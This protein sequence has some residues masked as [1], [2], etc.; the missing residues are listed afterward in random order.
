MNND[1]PVG[2]PWK[3][4]LFPGRHHALTKYQ[5]EW[6]KSCRE[7]K[8]KDDEGNLIT[9]DD[10]T[11]WIFVI[12]SANHHTTR[13]NP[14]SVSRRIAQVELFG[15]AENLRALTLTLSDVSDNLR[16][17]EH[18]VA[19][20]H[21]ELGLTLSPMDTLVAVSTPIGQQYKA[22]GYSLGLIEKDSL[23]EVKTPWQLVE[24]VVYGEGKLFTTYAHEASQ[25]VWSRYNLSDQVKQVFLD[26]VVSNED[27]AL[28]DTR[29][30]SSYAQAFE[31]SAMRKW[32]QISDWVIPGRIVDIGS[33]TGQLL[34][35]AG[36]D[37]RLSQSDLIGIEPDR[38]LHAQSVHR[39]EQGDFDNVN[40][41]FYRKNILNGDVFQPSSVDTTITA[42]LTHEIYSY[43]DGDNDL[44]KIVEIISKQTRQNGVW[45]NLDVCGPSNGDEIIRLRLK[46]DD[47][48]DLD[49]VDDIKSLSNAE[50]YQ[51]LFEASTWARFK[52]FNND[53][54]KFGERTSWLVNILEPGLVEISLK[55]AMEY[56]LHKDYADNWIS[57]LYES[58]TYRDWTGWVDLI[59][60][61]GMSVVPGSGL[62]LNQ[63]IVDNRFDTSAGLTNLDGK[64]L[65]WPATHMC[66]V[67]SKN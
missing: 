60:S 65:P 56:M 43:G 14:V 66:L 7:G 21:V 50:V 36:R 5:A 54:P 53:W 25:D 26:G 33:A 39:I 19:S 15:K 29:E 17:A 51:R 64:D 18:V 42:A 44:K 20:V 46:Q 11:S 6:I 37:N 57:E 67:A 3:Y 49:V 24:D 41:F 52:Q 10:D 59:E 22:L 1:K 47:G 55:N 23:S 2:S 4:I 63:W 9:V 32:A 34:V 13:R 35:E 61:A 12:T 58:F 45:I 30:Y 16:F 38:W 31:D 62:Y 28:T 40:T 27:G 48:G 8:I